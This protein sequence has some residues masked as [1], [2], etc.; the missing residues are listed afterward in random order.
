[1]RHQLKGL[2]DRAGFPGQGISADEDILA[3]R[4]LFPDYSVVVPLVVVGIEAL[5]FKSPN[6]EYVSRL[7]ERR[8]L[9]DD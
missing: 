9:P 6:T 1:M 2:I 4:E 7:E 3:A 8:M 5:L